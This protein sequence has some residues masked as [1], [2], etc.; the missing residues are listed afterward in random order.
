MRLLRYFVFLVALS[1][2]IDLNGAERDSLISHSENVKKGFNLGALPSVLFNSDLGFQYGALANL[3]DYG[4]GSTYPLY[5]YSLY[6]EWSRTTKGGGINQLNF[7]APSLLPGET[8][9][10]ADFSYLTQQALDF[11]GFNGKQVKYD[12]NY[13]DKESPLFISQMFYRLERKLVRVELSMQKP[14][15]G[16]KWQLLLGGAYMNFK[17]GGV[18]LEKLNS[19]RANDDL[20]PD[21]PSFYE[22]YIEWGMI[23]EEESN[24]GNINYVRTGLIY[25]SRDNEANPNRGVWAE[26]IVTVAPTFLG[27]ESGF[28]RLSVVLRGYKTV[29][30]DRMTLAGRVGYQGTI[31][32]VTPF[33]FQSYLL[34]S[35]V[36][37]T[38]IDGLGG[39][40][41]IRGVLRNRVVGDGLLYF[42]VEL[43]YKVI[44]GRWLGQNFYV[45][46]STFYDAGTVSDQ[47][48]VSYK[49]VSEGDLSRYFNIKKKN[50]PYQVIESDLLH[51][52]VGGGLHVAMN[53]NFVLA[54]D[55]ARALD[56]EDGYS[57]LYVG[58]NWMF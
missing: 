46:L 18:D 39:N 21:V 15:F 25:D 52:G 53:E 3:F 6:G 45:A 35:Q 13:E 41:S 1:G 7:D 56:K 28:T 49:K 8:R 43:R 47:I 57:G 55:Y 14:I 12:A 9:L 40:R 22:R 38:N 10:T 29:V 32:G 2:V 36:K 30:K 17:I 31:T 23:G 51:S 20:I 27:N 58:L 4:D 26:G 24:G 54:I 50:L 11:Y 37:T 19:G 34:N 44:V 33:Y 16:K 42:N 5:R 48:E